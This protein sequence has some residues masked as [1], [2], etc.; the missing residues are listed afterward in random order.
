MT[1]LADYD[2]FGLD[3]QS[4]ADPY[5]FFDQ[6]RQAGPVYQDPRTGTFIVLG[7]DEII[8]VAR[9]TDRFSSIVAPTGP[10]T[11]FPGPLEGDDLTETIARYRP[12]MIGAIPLLTLDPPEHGRYRQLV[13]R[14]FTPGRLKELE[15]FVRSLA[16]ELID[17][18]APAGEVEFV[19]RFA[20]PYP[21]LVIADLLGV[22]RQDQREF[23]RLLQDEQPDTDLVGNPGGDQAAINGELT[24]FILSTFTKYIEERRAEP[25]HDILSA[26]ANSTF[27]DTGELPGV[28]E[29]V[30]ISFVVFGA[31][32]E[33]TS[34][35]FTN[36]MFLL[37][38]RPDLADQL[39]REPEGLD[40]FVEEVLR[41]ETPVKGLFRLAKVDAEVAGTKVPAG[42]ILMLAFAAANRDP[43]TFADPDRFD[44]GRD[45]ERPTMSFGHGAH[46]C[47]GA[48]LARLEGRLGFEVLLRRMDNIALLDD[49]DPEP[50]PSFVLRGLKELRI[51]FDAAP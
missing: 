51:R 19:H 29:L 18:F 15:P 28:F 23:K 33:T 42:S 48:S 49:R 2:Y 31:G 17:E 44:P 14:F 10:L 38:G 12:K 25:R 21:L 39:R 37:A 36:G 9:D 16:H 11:A 27:A 45:T 6:A 3:R 8:E 30:A 13:G 1:S 22:P 32:Q 24:S 20:G 43:G 46:F 47:P 50:V 7:Y 41:Y 34:R 40:R 26:I 4:L 5:R 35:L